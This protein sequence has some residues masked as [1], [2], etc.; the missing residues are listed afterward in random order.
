MAG[1]MAA[2]QI[3][4]NFL[5]FVAF[6][7]AFGIGVDYSV[8]VLKRYLWELEHGT[9]REESVRLAISETGGAV[10]LCSL[11]TIIGYS[12]LYV[13]ANRALNTF[14]ASA[15]LSEITNLITA[16]IAMPALMLILGRRRHAS[17]ERAPS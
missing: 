7:I 5:N 11:T 15:T 3:K 16:G 10:A 12:S 1:A 2:L 17:Q 6:P 4:L 13:S 14:G 9:A 8:N